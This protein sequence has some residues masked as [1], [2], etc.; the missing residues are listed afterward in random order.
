[1][2]SHASIPWIINHRFPNGSTVQ[3]HKGMAYPSRIQHSIPNQESI[4]LKHSLN[5]LAMAVQK[6]LLRVIFPQ[7]NG[8]NLT[9]SIR[10]P[11]RLLTAAS[12]PPYPGW[13][14]T[15]VKFLLY[16]SPTILQATIQ[17]QFVRF[18]M[19]SILLFSYLPSS[20]LSNFFIISVPL[21]CMIL[22]RYVHSVSH[23]LISTKSASAE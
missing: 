13:K 12:F 21:S 18:C 9:T 23:L 2:D 16:C 5:L 14:E 1:M 17:H 4:F 6:A 20:G 19:Y 3:Y 22:L 15:S 11:S 8:V 10:S 7:G